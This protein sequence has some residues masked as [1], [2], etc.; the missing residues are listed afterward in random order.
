VHIATDA[1]LPE[2]CRAS[3]PKWSAVG[4]T[5]PKKEL[6]RRADATRAAPPP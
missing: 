5:T 6:A 2:N 1:C 4:P 3:L